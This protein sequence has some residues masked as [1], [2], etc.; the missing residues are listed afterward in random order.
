MFSN[1]CHGNCPKNIFYNFALYLTVIFAL[2]G[3]NNFVKLKKK[4]EKKVDLD[5][6][7]NGEEK[8]SEAK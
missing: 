2:D 7:K 8:K 4:V 6:K 3:I 5:R 1:F